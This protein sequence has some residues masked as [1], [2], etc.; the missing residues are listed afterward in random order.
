MIIKIKLTEEQ[1]NMLVARSAAYEEK[2][3]KSVQTESK[4]MHPYSIDLAK[5]GLAADYEK[6]RVISDKVFAWQDIIVEKK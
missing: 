6:G 4:D 2:S 1:A 3:K 5:V